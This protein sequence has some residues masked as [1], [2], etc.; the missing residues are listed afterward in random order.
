MVRLVSLIFILM[1]LT[2]FVLHVRYG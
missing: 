1:S 2:M